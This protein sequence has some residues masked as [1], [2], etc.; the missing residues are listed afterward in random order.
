MTVMK[1]REII[2][3]RALRVYNK[4]REIVEANPKNYDKELVYKLMMEEQ[5]ILTELKKL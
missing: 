5:K 1:A 4:A 2:K 3:E